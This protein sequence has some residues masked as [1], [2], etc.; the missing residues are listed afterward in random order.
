MITADDI[1]ATRPCA[2]FPRARVETLIAK[3]GPFASW[4]HLAEVAHAAGWPVSLADLR[5]TAYRAATPK[6]RETAVRDSTRIRVESQAKHWTNP[7]EEVAGIRARLLAWAAGGPEDIRQ[8]LADI[9]VV[10]DD[11]DA[12][13]ATARAARD[14]ATSCA[15]YAHIND[16]ARAARATTAARANDANDDARLGSLLYICSLLD[17]AA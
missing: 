14:A 8:I 9:I 1:M 11:D 13:Y 2:D 15:I 10:G 6:Q 12:A 16:A 5:L 7:T 17:G 3:Y 4:T